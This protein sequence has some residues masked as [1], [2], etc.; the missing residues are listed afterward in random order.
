MLRYG[1]NQS[2]AKGADQRIISFSFSCLYYSYISL[3]TFKY[4]KCPVI[5]LFLAS[6]FDFWQKYQAIGAHAMYCQKPM[7]IRINEII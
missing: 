3:F 5:V 7:T 4:R 2:L 6:T 1:Y